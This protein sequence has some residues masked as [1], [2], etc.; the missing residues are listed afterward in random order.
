MLISDSNVKLCNFN[1]NIVMVYPAIGYV[2]EFGVCMHSTWTSMSHDR[3]GTS[4]ARIAAVYLAMYISTCFISF[5]F[6]I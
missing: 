1:L 5:E 4:A 6:I 3:R 2:M